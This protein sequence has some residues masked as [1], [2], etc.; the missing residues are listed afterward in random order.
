ML[1]DEID[2]LLDIGTGTGRMLEL[3]GAEAERAIGIDIS[4]DMLAVAR[5]ILERAGLVNCQVRKA[6]MYRL[7]LGSETF[8]AVVLH[9]VLHYAESPRQVI[10]EAARVLE[11]G[12]RLLI[13]DFAPHQE[14]QLRESH[15]H[16]WM[17]FGETEIEA[18][19]QSF[20]LQP[21]PVRRLE[22]APLTVCVWTAERPDTRA[23]GAPEGERRG[24]LESTG[25]QAGA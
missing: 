1:P 22:G 3:L 2:D 15:H 14:E 5:A 16:R 25:G 19:L 24:E 18:W 12:G 20:G 4:T 10:G 7:P 6:D 11:P 9:M 17:G 21:A 13:V 23:H 8:D